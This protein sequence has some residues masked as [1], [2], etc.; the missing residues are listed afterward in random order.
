MF[1]EMEKFA[2]AVTREVRNT[3]REGKAASVVAAA[4]D[5]GA[6]IED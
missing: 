1:E 6:S 4:R 5:Y 2:G 3:E